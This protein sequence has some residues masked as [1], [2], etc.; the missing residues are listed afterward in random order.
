MHGS[1]AVGAAIQHG[2]NIVTANEVIVEPEGRN[3]APCIF[4]S[5]LKLL[6]DGHSEESVV[7]VLPSDHIILDKQGFTKTLKKQGARP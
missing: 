5:L 4:L 2:A 1:R 6:K 3:T 7:A